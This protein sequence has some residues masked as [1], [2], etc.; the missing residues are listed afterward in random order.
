MRGRGQDATS[1]LIAILVFGLVGG[2]VSLPIWAG[3]RIVASIRYGID[4]G[5]HL[6]RAAD[7]N[8]I[9]LAKQEL[10]VATSY[11]ERHGMTAGYTSVLYNEP[12]EDVGFWYKN[13]DMSLQELEK[14]PATASELE[15]SNLL[16]KL[17]Q[18][19]LDTSSGTE[20]VTEPSGISIFPHNAAYAWWVWISLLAVVVGFIAA[21]GSG[22]NRKGKPASHEPALQ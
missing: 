21:L 18:T 20:S 22:K 8:N 15:K 12:S 11:L 6:K 10:A 3:V 9:E 2:L 19:L 7:A 14:E 17:R 1:P 16:L 5:G 13:L 4:C